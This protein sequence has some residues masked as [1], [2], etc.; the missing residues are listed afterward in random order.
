MKTRLPQ[1]KYKSRFIKEIIKNSISS[2]LLGNL[3]F[4]HHPLK[5][6]LFELCTMLTL[7]S[8]QRGEAVVNKA[9]CKA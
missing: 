2:L 7:G 3:G 9:K 8:S 5:G 1:T 4:Q 6:L